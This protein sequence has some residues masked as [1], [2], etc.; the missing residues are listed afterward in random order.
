MDVRLW[1]KEM[2][3]EFIDMYRSFPC[4]WKC[5]TEEYKNKNLRDNALSAMIDLCKARG[6]PEANRDFV[7][8]K[9]Q[10]LRGSFRKELKKVLDSERS[11]RGTEEIYTPS[12]W[13]FDLLMFTKEQE[14]PAAS[15]SNLD[16]DEA[17]EDETVEEEKPRTP[18]KTVG[19]TITPRSGDCVQ[20]SPLL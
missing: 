17:Q 9:I 5:K 20:D 8:K 16:N 19:L 2:V 3:T 1:S 7:A 15:I 13:Y 6:F 14:V 10:S 11:G 18:T 12:L 4:L